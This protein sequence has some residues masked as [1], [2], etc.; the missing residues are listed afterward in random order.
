MF[1][2][3]NILLYKEKLNKANSHEIYIYKQTLEVKAPTPSQTI[4]AKEIQAVDFAKHSKSRV[5]TS[6]NIKLSRCQR[7][8]N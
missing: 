1:S 5:D 7:Q 6:K 3:L 2:L 8:D 4:Y